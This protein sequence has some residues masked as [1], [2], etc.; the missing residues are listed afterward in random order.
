M[1]SI[2][3]VSTSPKHHFFGYHDLC[4][5]DETGRYLLAMEVDFLDKMPKSG[6]E[7]GV[8]LIDTKNNNKIEVLAKTKAWNFQEGARAQWVPKH[9]KKIIYNDQD[10]NGRLI[11]VLFNVETRKKELETEYPIHTVSPDGTY[12]LGVDYSSLGKLGSYGYMLVGGKNSTEIEGSKDPFS[13]EKSSG[14]VKI[15][16]NTGKAETIIYTYNIAN[17][18]H[19]LVENEHHVLNHVTFNPSGVRIAFFDKYRLP[20]GGFMQRLVTAN[21]DGSDPY[22]LPGHITHY[23]WR[24]NTEILAFG[25]WSPRVTALRGRGT[26]QNPILKPLLHIARNMRGVIKQKIAGQSYFLLTDGTKKVERVAVGVMTEDGHPQFSP[27][28]KWVATDTYPD[29]KRERTLILYNWE[30]KKR[31]NVAKLYS[32]PNNVKDGWDLSGMRSDLHPRWNRDGTKICIDSVH[33]GSRQM[34]VVDVDKMLE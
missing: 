10:E 28:R 30:K 29:K 31:I 1:K 27:D 5:W 20:D 13:R 3:P 17:H 7:A 11:S 4:P 23:D 25:K 33:E 22:V 16:L 21:S 8:C 9:P 32:M 15:D 26:F 12:G 14:I 19:K 18:E 6:E 34:Y 24:N 2:Q